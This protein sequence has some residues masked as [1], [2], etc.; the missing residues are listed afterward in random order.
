[1]V[2]PGGSLEERT[3]AA[4]RG[5]LGLSQQEGRDHVWAVDIRPGLGAKINLFYNLASLRSCVINNGIRAEAEVYFG[6]RV[7]KAQDALPTCAEGLGGT[8]RG[9]NSWWGKEPS[10]CV[11]R[12]QSACSKRPLFQPPV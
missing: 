7:W 6:F 8:S 10:R 1:M 4:L 12:T 2:E 5:A 11:Q 3:H 9:F